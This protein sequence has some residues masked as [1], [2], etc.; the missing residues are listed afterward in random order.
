MFSMLKLVACIFKVNASNY[1]AVN[2]REVN[3]RFTT[4]VNRTL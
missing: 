3:K 1:D 2:A 4:E